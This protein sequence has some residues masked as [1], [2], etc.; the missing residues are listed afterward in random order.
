MFIS[1]NTS[2]PKDLVPPGR[3]RI[4]WLWNNGEVRNAD[5]NK[6]SANIG[7]SREQDEEKD[8]NIFEVKQLDLHVTRSS[9]RE[10]TGKM[11]DSLMGPELRSWLD[12]DIQNPTAKLRC[13]KRQAPY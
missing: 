4:F 13:F 3:F 2:F 9:A 8:V 1:L 10:V 7:R 11:D 12:L 6:E 5:V